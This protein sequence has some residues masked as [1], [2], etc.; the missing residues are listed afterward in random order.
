MQSENHPVLCLGFPPA[1]PQ[2]TPASR[3]PGESVL[4]KTGSASPLWQRGRLSCVFSCVPSVCAPVSLL[5]W[6]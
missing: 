4:S 1:F 5:S 3:R 6:R 2:Q